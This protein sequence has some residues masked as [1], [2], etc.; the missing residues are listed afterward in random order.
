MAYVVVAATVA[1][2]PAEIAEDPVSADINRVVELS[3][4]PRLPKVLGLGRFSYELLL[5]SFSVGE[6]WSPLSGLLLQL[7]V[8]Q[9]EPHLHFL[10]GKDVTGNKNGASKY[11]VSEKNDNKVI[12]SLSIVIQT[13][14]LKLQLLKTMNFINIKQY[15]ILYFP[16]K[17]AYQ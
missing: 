8:F 16:P 6:L 3:V 17:K 7:I 13:E 1:G 9:A 2:T 14:F 4:V 12:H 5:V 15:E 10:L 11:T